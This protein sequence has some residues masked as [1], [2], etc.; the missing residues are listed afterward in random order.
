MQS[1]G[2]PSSQYFRSYLWLS[3]FLESSGKFSRLAFRPHVRVMFILD[4]MPPLLTYLSSEWLKKLFASLTVKSAVRLGISGRQGEVWIPVLHLSGSE[5][6]EE[7]VVPPPP[8][9]RLL[10]GLDKIMGIYEASHGSR[11]RLS[12]QLVSLLPSSTSLTPQPPAIPSLPFE[13]S[14]LCQNSGLL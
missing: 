5:V 7:T 10:A 4:S 9:H 6:P 12:A 13:L 3:L 2:S 1:D 11:H 14:S 8:P